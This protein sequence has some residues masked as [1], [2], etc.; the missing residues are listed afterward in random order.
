MRRQP[1]PGSR[2]DRTSSTIWS[3]ARESFST[4]KST[5]LERISSFGLTS[6]LTSHEQRLHSPETRRNADHA[7]PTQSL[8]NFARC[9]PCH[10][11]APLHSYSIIEWKTLDQVLDSLL[12][13]NMG[14]NYIFYHKLTSFSRCSVL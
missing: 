2:V 12:S 4:M 10:S 11:C 14:N 13:F 1:P 9:H 3:E 6:R 8:V 7:A 5:F